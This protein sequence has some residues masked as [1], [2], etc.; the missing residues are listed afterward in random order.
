MCVHSPEYWNLVT[1]APEISNGFKSGSSSLN[2]YLSKVA[3]FRGVRS[4]HRNR[5]SEWIWLYSLDVN[6]KA[7][8]DRRKDI[9]ALALSRL[10]GGETST[11]YK[12]LMLHWRRKL[13]RENPNLQRKPGFCPMI[14]QRN[15]CTL[16][17]DEAYRF[18][19]QWRALRPRNC[20][21]GFGTFRSRRTVWQR[22]DNQDQYRLHSKSLQA[23]EMKPESPSNCSESSIV[24]W[25]RQ[26]PRRLLHLP[27]W[28]EEDQMRRLLSHQRTRLMGRGALGRATHWGTF[29][30][31]LVHRRWQHSN[32]Q[33][34]HRIT[35]GLVGVNLSSV[36]TWW[37]PFVLDCQARFLSRLDSPV[38]RDLEGYLRWCGRDVQPNNRGIF[39]RDTGIDR[40]IR[41]VAFCYQVLITNRY[42]M[43]GC[44]EIIN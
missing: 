18:W 1:W 22:K 20:N 44:V 6:L 43:R 32:T 31:W 13:P 34:H 39:A 28:Y 42:V 24:R 7:V 15:K 25:I 3:M 19:Y 41:R 23:M 16:P 21:L 10:Y 33:S 38:L 37:V 2:G 4:W 27:T 9:S 30:S 35:S 5:S 36:G 29:G 12:L 14:D 17:P 26:E 40:S 8:S 11:L